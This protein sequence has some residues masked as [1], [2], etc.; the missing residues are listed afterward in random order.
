MKLNIILF[1]AFLM[2]S[3]TGGAVT[4]HLNSTEILV[5]LNM[6]NL[7]ILPRNFRMSTDPLD[8]TSKPPSTIGMDRLNISGSGQFSQRSFETMLNTIP[9]NNVMIIDLREE[10]HGFLNGHAFG[11]YSNLNLGNLGKTAQEIFQDE[12]NKLQGAINIP[13][14]RFY[15]KD[16]HNPQAMTVKAAYNEL[17]LVNHYGASYYR[18]PCTDHRRPSDAIVDELVGFLKSR[19][20]HVWLH[21]HCSAGKG[22]SSTFMVMTDIFYNAKYVSLEDIVARQVLIGGKDFWRLPNADSW[23]YDS[24]VDRIDFLKDFYNYCQTAPE[25]QSWTQWLLERN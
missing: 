6:D 19:P 14:L 24:M 17:T 15:R 13:E 2:I 23:K 11:W 20:S 22:R 9:S 25:N 5:L 1:V 10:S 7:P 12:Y 4:K 3:V 16:D 21:F 18:L 8:H